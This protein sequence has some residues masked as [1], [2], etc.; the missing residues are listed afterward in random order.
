[1]FS[2]LFTVRSLIPALLLGFTCNWQWQ[3]LDYCSRKWMMSF[4]GG[5]RK[6]SAAFATHSL[7]NV[8]KWQTDFVPLGKPQ[9]IACVLRWSLMKCQGSSQRPLDLIHAVILVRKLLL[10]NKYNCLKMQ[11]WYNL[12]SIAAESTEMRFIP[13]DIHSY[14][15]FSYACTLSHIVACLTSWKA[16]A[17]EPFLPKDPASLRIRI[18]K[19]QHIYSRVSLSRAH[20]IY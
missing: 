12:S 11:A 9:K 18:V 17:I 8:A 20:M 4:L 7:V 1:M 14:Y 6:T 15:F 5:E 19:T 2:A 10:C 16:H 3:R 13:A